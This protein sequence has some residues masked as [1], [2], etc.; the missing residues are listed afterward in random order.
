MLRRLFA[1][2]GF[3][4][5]VGALAGPASAGTIGTTS[6]SLVGCGGPFT[7]FE[8]SVASPGLSYTI[9]AGGGTITSWSTQ[10]G[11]VGGQMALVVGRPTGTLDQYRIVAESATESLTASSLNTFA[12]S[13]GVQG[14]DVVGYYIPSLEDCAFFTGNGGDSLDLGF[15]GPPTIGSVFGTPSRNARFILNLS[16]SLAPA[17]AGVAQV[18]NVFLCYSKFEQDGGAV[19]NVDQQDALLKNGF[20]TPDAVAGNVPGGDN[21]GAYH[22]VCNLPSGLAQTDQLLDDGGN[23]IPVSAVGAS[24]DGLYAIAG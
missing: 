19:F 1:V 16:V 21:I 23:V 14:G 5:L 20:W 24:T 15:G 10:A 22:L 6:G 3:A 8:S 2:T 13:I 11:P 7:A 17:G 18:N 4:C 12:V 9:P